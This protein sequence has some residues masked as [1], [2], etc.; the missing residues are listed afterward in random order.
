MD[1]RKR[2][3]RR[4]FR[5]DTIHHLGEGMSVSKGELGRARRGE[6][7]WMRALALLADLFADVLVV[8]EVDFTKELPAPPE[9]LNGLRSTAARSVLTTSR[10]GRTVENAPNVFEVDSRDEERKERREEMGGNVRV[11]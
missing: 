1:I 4:T 11:N 10:R 9:P 6:G 8:T 5:R 3:V 7:L 2:P